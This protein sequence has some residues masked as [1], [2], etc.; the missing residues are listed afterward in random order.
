MCANK[1]EIPL[2][3]SYNYVVILSWPLSEGHHGCIDRSARAALAQMTSH[4]Y[5]K[6]H[7]SQNH[8]YYYVYWGCV[9]RGTV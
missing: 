9:T 7:L 2:G 4:T 1:I 5:G 3:V 6:D 8:K